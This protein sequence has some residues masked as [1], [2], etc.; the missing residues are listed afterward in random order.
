MYHMRKKIKNFSPDIVHAH[1]GISG[2]VANLQRKVPV[3][4]TFHGSDAY[5]PKVRLLS[6]IAAGLSGFNIFVSAKFIIRYEEIRCI[7]LF[8]VE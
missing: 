4:I 6:K 7:Q 1:F 8:L 5:L 3:V 2:L